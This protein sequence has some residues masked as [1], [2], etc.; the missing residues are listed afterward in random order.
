MQA[1]G[2]TFLAALV[3]SLTSVVFLDLFF[4]KSENQV[5]AAKTKCSTIT[6]KFNEEGASAILY[7]S[8]HYLEGQLI[9]PGYDDY[10]YNYQANM[11]NGSY[12]NVYLGRDGYPPYKWDDNAYIAEN[13]GVESY[14]AWPYRHIQLEMKWNNAWISNSDCDLDGKLDRHFGYESYIG[15]GAWE[16]NH[17]KPHPDYVEE[18]GGNWT[19]FAKIVAVPESANPE[20]GVWYA[21]DGGEI[22]AQI[23]GDFAVIQEIDTDLG[24]KY[25]SPAGPGFGKF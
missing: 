4:P 13:P 16:T 2:G 23:W 19:Y 18:E 9:R 14:W 20:N 10:G 24:T 8:G 12:V 5:L 22:G 11:F 15:S 17:M 1:V 7:S 21:E 6:G 3:I 25:V